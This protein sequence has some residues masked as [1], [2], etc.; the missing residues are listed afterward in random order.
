MAQV[1]HE[2]ACLTVTPPRARA[3]CMN[4]VGVNDVISQVTAYL[5]ACL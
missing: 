3:V 4:S 1:E 5:P 2:R